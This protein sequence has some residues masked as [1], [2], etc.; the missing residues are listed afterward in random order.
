DRWTFTRIGGQRITAAQ[1]TRTIAY[2]VE[3]ETRYGERAL[4]ADLIADVT[5]MEHPYADAIRPTW[6][7]EAGGGRT[8]A[9][10]LLDNAEH[11]DL[12]Q[13]DVVAVA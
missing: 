7:G 8:A 10:A 4:L 13:S 6:G 3:N 1:T 12:Q 2:D 5:D 11:L 9:D